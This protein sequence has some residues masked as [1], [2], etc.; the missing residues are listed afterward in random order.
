MKTNPTTSGFTPLLLATLTAGMLIAGAQADEKASDVS[1]PGPGC[2]TPRCTPSPMRRSVKVSA[3]VKGTKV[4]GWVVT[5]KKG[6]TI[7]STA[8]RC[9][10]AAVNEGLAEV[11]RAL[12]AAAQT[13]GQRVTGAPFG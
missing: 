12:G 11:E 5:N 1:R 4:A 13:R 9:Q 6:K 3:V 8:H 2:W 7:P 10:L